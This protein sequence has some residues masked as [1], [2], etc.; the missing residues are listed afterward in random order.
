MIIRKE[1][2][3]HIGFR[4]KPRAAGNEESKPKKNIPLHIIIMFCLL[5][6]NDFYYC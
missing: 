1:A 2:I 3:E 6:V 5:Y 4:H